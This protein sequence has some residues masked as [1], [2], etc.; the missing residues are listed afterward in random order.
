MALHSKK[1]EKKSIGNRYIV[2]DNIFYYLKYYENYNFEDGGNSSTNYIYHTNM[3]LLMIATTI[4]ECKI[5]INM[6]NNDN[7]NNIIES[8]DNHNHNNNDQNNDDN[9]NN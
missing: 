4:R 7:M 8:N 3:I 1:R 6:I 5:I 9:D 2:F